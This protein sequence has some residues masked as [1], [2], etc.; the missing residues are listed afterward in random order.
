MTALVDAFSTF[1]PDHPV[2]KVGS[3]HYLLAP[4]AEVG[5]LFETFH[6]EM[7]TVPRAAGGLYPILSLGEDKAVDALSHDWW[8]GLVLRPDEGG[9]LSENW[10][11]ETLARPATSHLP[12]V[13]ACGLDGF[14]RP[15][16]LAAFL[17]RLPSRPVV[18]T[19]G[20]QLNVSGL[21]LE[22]AEALFKGYSHTFLETSGIYRQDFLERM[23]D[24]LG[25]ER[26]LYGSGHPLMHETLEAERVRTLPVDEGKRA[27]I[28]GG[29]AVRLFNLA[30]LTG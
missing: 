14:S 7:E 23:V 2:T 29:N 21:H 16:H 27:A 3:F 4:P 1:T 13:V 15:E 22:A 19:H 9:S 18:L 11:F 25:Y 10:L 20:G 12:I 28:L 24:E 26:V 5:G 8:R 17:E 30:D 6:Q